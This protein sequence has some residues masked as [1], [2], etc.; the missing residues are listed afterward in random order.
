MFVFVLFDDY[1][2]VM[3]PALFFFI[4]IALA[5]QD[6]LSFHINF[7]VVFISVKNAIGILTGIALNL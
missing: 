3:S 2:F 6:V 1:S 7:R 5:I 4:K